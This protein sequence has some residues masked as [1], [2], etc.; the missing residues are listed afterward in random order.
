[1]LVEHSRLAG[2]ILELAPAREGEA[3]GLDHR[4]DVVFCRIIII[5]GK[6]SPINHGGILPRSPL[7]F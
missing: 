3:L 7:C 2:A 6:G 4:C 1:M 5:A